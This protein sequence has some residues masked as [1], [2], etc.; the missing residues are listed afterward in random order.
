MTE[1]NRHVD[2]LNEA[3]KKKWLLQRGWIPEGVGYREPD[4]GIVFMF[5]TALERAKNECKFPND[6]LLALPG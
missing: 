4:T 3:E 2:F 1:K 5:S 6:Y